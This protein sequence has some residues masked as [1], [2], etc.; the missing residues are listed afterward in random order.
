[1]V[2]L[3]KDERET[4]ITRC[5]DEDYWDV[6]SCSPPVMRKIR[7]I[8]EH[9]GIEVKEDDIGIRAKLPLTAIKIT[10]PRKKRQISEEERERRRQ[11]GKV[12]GASRRRRVKNNEQ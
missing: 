2:R 1:M 6:Y 12:L 9:E 11:Q 3:S 8:A 10:T 7:K 4:V 5:D